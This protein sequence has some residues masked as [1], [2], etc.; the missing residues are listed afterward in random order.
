MSYTPTK[1]QQDI[2]DAVMEMVM[3]PGKKIGAVKALAAAGSGKTSTLIMISKKIL[4]AK[5]GA[6]ILYLAYNKVIKDEAQEKLGHLVTAQTT[7]SMAMSHTLDRKKGRNI[8]SLNANHVGIC[9]GSHVSDINR[10]LVIATMT[11][12]CNSIDASA[13]T[14]H[15]PSRFNGIAISDD[16]KKEIV[17]LTDELFWEVCPEGGNIEIPV[18]HDSYLKYWQIIGSPGLNEYDCVTVD[19]G[20]DSS[21]VVLAALENANCAIY[22]GDSEQAIYGWRDAINGLEKVSGKCYPITQSF[23]FGPV[24]ADL[25]NLILSQKHQKP[26]FSVKGFQNLNTTIGNVDRKSKNARI[27]RTN[28]SLIREALVLKDRN[29]LFAIA[30]N[31]DEFRDMIE[32]LLIVK[33]DKDVRESGRYIKNSKVKYLK[34]WE[35]IIEEVNNGSD[36]NDLYQGVKLLEEFDGRVHEIIDILSNYKDESTAKV[37][38]TTAHRS[39]GREWN[40]VIISPDFDPIIERAKESKAQWDPEMNLLYVTV[41]RAMQ[42]LEIN[43][44]FLNELIETSKKPY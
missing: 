28:R 21:P 6:K 44:V 24:I 22:V 2:I 37:V 7:H 1:E 17:E 15:V 5:P 42:R 32:S 16:R 18:T 31:N 13:R 14:I 10:K 30:G 33:E 26:S 27:F 9:L 12:F 11:K 40:Q 38:L 39:K 20:Q 36:A 19:E 4:E 23:R 41:T 25:A 35:N 43:S 29:I 8:G 34:T 3:E